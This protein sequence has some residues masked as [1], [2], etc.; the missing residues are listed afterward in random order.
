[1]SIKY[2]NWEASEKLNGAEAIGA[3]RRDCPALCMRDVR[4][5]DNGYGREC[6]LAGMEDV[7]NR[8]YKNLHQF[9][10]YNNTLEAEASANIFFKCQTPSI[11]ESGNSYNS[12]C[13][14]HFKRNA[15]PLLEAGIGCEVQL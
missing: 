14:G 11:S 5:L 4:E 7:V 13:R 1:M 6:F 2:W 8:G 15:P 3:H 9:S 12:S 10:N